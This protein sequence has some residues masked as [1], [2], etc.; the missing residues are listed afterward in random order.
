VC[1]CVCVCSRAREEG[2]CLH[3]CV[4]VCLLAYVRLYVYVHLRVQEC[5]QR[6]LTVSPGQQPALHIPYKNTDL[7]KSCF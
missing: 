6:L 4:M 7:E 2:G 1:V 5:G 3:V